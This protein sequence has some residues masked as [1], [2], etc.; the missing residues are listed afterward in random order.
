MASPKT[1]N[2]SLTGKGKKFGIVVG[3]FNEFISSKLLN[4]AVEA[5][6]SHDVNESDIEIAWVPG[7]FEVPMIARRMS[8][9]GKYS[10]IICLG[11]IIRGETPHFDFIASEAAKGVA[12]V[13]LDGN[14]PCAFGILTC[15]TIKQALERAGGKI[16]NKGREAA[17]S[18]IEM[19]NLYGVI[20]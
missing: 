2:V 18:A 3:R 1:I 5:L 12:N 16:G 9:T 17:L 11:V 7:S 10:A 8:N 13:A 6:A 19:A 15:D 4:G 14:A 20:K